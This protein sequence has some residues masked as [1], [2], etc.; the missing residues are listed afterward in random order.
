MD[1]DEA[2]VDYLDIVRS[3]LRP[4][5]T[6]KRVLIA[7][8]GMAGLV[9]AYELLRAGHDPLVLEARPRAG[10]RIHTLR[11]P[12]AEGL[13]AEAG[14]MRLPAAHRLSLAYARKFELPLIA[15]TGA[16]P[17][18]WVYARG[19]RRRK[20]DGDPNP[21][22]FELAAGEEGRSAAQLLEQ[23]LHVIAEQWHAEGETAWP[24][25][26]ARYDGYSLRGFLE[27]AGWSEG[28]IERF[29][30]LYS[31]ETLLNAGFLEFLRDELEHS[32][33]GPL[34]ALEGGMDR[35]PQAFLAALGGRVRLQ[36][37]LIALEQSPDSVTFHC[38]TPAGREQFSGDYA[39]LALPF[40]TL[41]HVDILTPFSPAKQRAI[42]QLPYDAAC[43]V[44]LQCKRRFW[45][46]DEGIFGGSSV[47]DLPIRALYYPDHNRASGRGILLASY[48]WGE[49]ARC[50]QMLPPARRIE[51]A[52]TYVARLHPQV[53][54]SFELGASYAWTE[55]EYA[56]GAFALFAP[57][58]E[59]LLY[60]AII[61]PEGRIHFA[62]EHASRHHAWIQ[63]AL[64][65]GLRAAGAIAGIDI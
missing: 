21:W 11:Q 27:A 51:R 32:Y 20:S 7:G 54:E 34:Y 65:S 45:E 61:A 30:I 13:Y 15:F 47:T 50:W 10:G 55:D 14:A 41:Q 40:P 42:R 56:G 17:G 18:G 36:S 9:A 57:R 4:A 12:F 43:K 31:Q 64:E 6:P 49:D 39:I 48:T 33:N 58:Q 16:Q 22:G 46:D 62:G 44:Y 19:R 8:A 63:G 38:Q 26:S 35:L 23:T 24:A 25:L 53:T 2:S 5:G 37:P 60:A 28:A 59:T 1:M 3:G 52:T 29:G